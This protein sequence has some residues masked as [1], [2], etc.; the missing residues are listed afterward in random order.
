MA[1]DFTECEINGYACPPEKTP[2]WHWF[3]LIPMGIII[4]LVCMCAILIGKWEE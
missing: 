4:L 2:W 1:L 3:G